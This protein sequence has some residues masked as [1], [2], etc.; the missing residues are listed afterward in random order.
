MHSWMESTKCI[1]TNNFPCQCPLLCSLILHLWTYANTNHCIAYEPVFRFSYEKTSEKMMVQ[2]IK[3][4]THTHIVDVNASSH[5]MRSFFC[6][7]CRFLWSVFFFLLIYTMYTRVSDYAYVCI[8]LWFPFRCTNEA[9][10]NLRLVHYDISVHHPS[11]GRFIVRHHKKK[12]FAEHQL[13]LI[14]FE[15]LLLFRRICFKCQIVFDAWGILAATG[16]EIYLSYNGSALH[17]SQLHCFFFIY[18]HCI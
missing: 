1:D 11:F 9:T 18:F 13:F 16:S 5:C 17:S 8:E 2:W 15:I 10:E 6:I 4:L 7:D 12:R 3:K 14:Q